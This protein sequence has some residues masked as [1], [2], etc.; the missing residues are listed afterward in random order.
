MANYKARQLTALVICLVAIIGTYALHKYNKATSKEHLDEYLDESSEKP[1][2]LGFARWT[3]HTRKEDS[4]TR[5]IVEIVTPAGTITQ[6]LPLGYR[7][8]KHEFAP[9][10][11][12]RK[13]VSVGFVWRKEYASYTQIKKLQTPRN[14]KNLKYR[15]VNNSS[16]RRV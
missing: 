6:K 9:H 4:H 16:I 15:I 10:L 11:G 14:K 13:R 5:Y 1:D 12:T 7:P 3:Y 2:A 8:K